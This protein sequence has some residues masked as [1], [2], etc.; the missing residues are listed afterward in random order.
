ML[1]LVGPL[2]FMIHCADQ[3]IIEDEFNS[4]FVTMIFKVILWFVF[5]NTQWIIH[6]LIGIIMVSVTVVATNL[7]MDLTFTDSFFIF[8][9]IYLN[10]HVEQTY[11]DSH[12]EKF[13]S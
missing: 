10:Y 3:F 2:W 6:T 13:V 12:C 7:E 8:V 5:F 11:K 1:W 9:T 4:F